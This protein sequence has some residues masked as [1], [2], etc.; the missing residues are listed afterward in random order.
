MVMRN[1][2]LSGLRFVLVIMA[3][4]T[5]PM[6]WF[7]SPR[8]GAQDDVMIVILIL[9]VV[10]IVMMGACIFTSTYPKGK[11]ARIYNPLLLILFMTC[12]AFVLPMLA[13]ATYQT[14]IF[15]ATAIAGNMY[16]SVEIGWRLARMRVRYRN[17][18]IRKWLDQLR[19]DERRR[20]ASNIS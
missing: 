9:R 6:L 3:I 20:E 14:S 2:L 1:H 12:W 7:P 17:K 5:A 13:S 19:E 8:I 15:I 16:L 4:V 10:C 11:N 18:K